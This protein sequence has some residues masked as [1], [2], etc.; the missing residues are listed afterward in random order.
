M[1]YENRYYKTISVDDLGSVDFNNLVNTQPS[2]RYNL[3]NDTFIV[4]YEGI[5]PLDVEV[6]E[7]ASNALTH[8]EAKSLMQTL[9]WKDTTVVGEL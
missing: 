8:A 1:R 9:A 3:T 2:L 5:C 6:C 7:S 4:E